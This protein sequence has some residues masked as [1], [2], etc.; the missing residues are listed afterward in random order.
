VRDARVAIGFPDILF[1]P[2]DVFTKALKRLSATRADIVLALCQVE[3]VQISDMIAIDRTGRVQEL[4]IKPNETKL[5]FGWVLAVWTPVFTEFMHGYLAVPR[6][7]AQ[8]PGAGLP[9][10]LSVGHVIQA[11]VQNGLHAQTVT[12][13]QD[14]YLDIGTPEGF[15]RAAAGQW[16]GK[17][18][19]ERSR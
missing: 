3:N 6:T 5:R 18:A 7:S 9:P 19:P 8:K 11:A 17:P 4:V 16:P 1:E 13:R 14:V 2:R 10:E 15:K 12:F